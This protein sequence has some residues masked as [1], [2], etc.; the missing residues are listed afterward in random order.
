M[1]KTKTQ[2]FGCNMQTIRIHCVFHIPSG[3]SQCRC[4]EQS[5]VVAPLAPALLSFSTFPRQPNFLLFYLFFFILAC[6]SSAGNLPWWSEIHWLD[7]RSYFYIIYKLFSTCTIVSF[8]VMFLFN[9]LYYIVVFAFL[10]CFSSLIF[11]FFV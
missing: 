1:Y 2:A 5:T 10:G 8:F 6:D 3:C 4:W 7:S 11:F 9:E